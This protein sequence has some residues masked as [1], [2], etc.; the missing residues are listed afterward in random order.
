MEQRIVLV[1]RIAARE[2]LSDTEHELSGIV[3]ERGVDG[4]V[5]SLKNCLL[6]KTLRNYNGD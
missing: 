5:L 6:R 1:E 4:Q 3:Y 2:K